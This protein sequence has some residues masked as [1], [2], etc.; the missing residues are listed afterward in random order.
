M[1]II[2]D[3]NL[4]MLLA[5]SLQNLGHDVHTTLG[6]GLTGQAD[7]AGWDA[8][9]AESRFLVTQDL[10]FA[11]LRQFA[12]GTHA[13]ILVIRLHDPS[14]RNLIATV[15]NLFQPEGVEQWR[16]CFVIATERKTRVIKP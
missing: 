12:P 4:P 16:G 9:Q 15:E 2:L 10:D 7:R 1:K 3:E 8:A 6:E 11:D 5:E 14:R 13:G